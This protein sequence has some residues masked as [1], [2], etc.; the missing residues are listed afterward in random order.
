M[1]TQTKEDK[2]V[3][4]KMRD[5]R[6]DIEEIIRDIQNTINDQRKW[7]GAQRGTAFKLRMKTLEELLRKAHVAAEKF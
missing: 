7:S 5:I 6:Y 3:E 2:F 1:A 4:D